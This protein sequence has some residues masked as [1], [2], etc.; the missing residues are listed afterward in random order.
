MFLQ[1]REPPASFACEAQTRF[2]VAAPGALVDHIFDLFDGRAAAI[3]RE[4]GGITASLFSGEASMH[5]TP[6]GLVVTV[7]A[8]DE[9][10]LSTLKG[11][12]ASQII[13]LAGDDRPTIVWTGDGAGARVFPNF[14]EMTVRRI[15]DV[16]PHMRRVTLA[17]RDL[18]RFAVGGMHL[19]LLVPPEGLEKP[20]WPTPG[21]DGLPV[22][23]PEERRP[24]L[25]TYTVRQ[26]DPDAGSIDVDFVL[27]G[28]PAESVGARWAALARPGDIVGVRGPV[29]RA[30]PE[31][32]WVL[33]AGDETALPVISRL[34]E[35]LPATTRGV[36]LVE[37]A[38]AS[39]EQPLEYA[40]DVELRWLHRGGAAAGESTVLTDAV[41]AIR[42]PAG[43]G[44]IY[45]M[46][47][48]EHAAARAIRAFW[49]DELGLDRRDMIAAAY[50][51]L[52]K[53][54]DDRRAE[55]D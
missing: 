45:A 9:G 52:G 47:G 17:G 15:V 2:S 20:E 31:A 43:V 10:A 4:E 40:A 35:T 54:E 34:L 53:A 36:A 29:G 32:D 49:R 37:V 19:H 55:R 14:R 22:W 6:S 16:T 18:A 46:A 21:P 5:E 38:D 13:A 1:T 7:R 33:L 27:H 25:R 30:T 41:C 50:W 42:P 26:V 51:R 48:A 8:T 44:R 24:R 11:L 28:D 23:P 39:E 12:M 3:R